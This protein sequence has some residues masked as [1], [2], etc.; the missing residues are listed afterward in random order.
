VDVA[1]DKGPPTVRPK[2][3]A[4]PMVELDGGTKPKTGRFESKIEAPGSGEQTNYGR[5]WH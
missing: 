1:L 3:L 2:R 5:H 4:R